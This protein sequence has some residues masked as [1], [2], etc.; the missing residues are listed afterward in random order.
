MRASR[1]VA[2]VVL[3]PLAACTG[4]ESRTPRAAPPTS[5]APASSVTT[6]PS[7]SG[8]LTPATQ[9]V[10]YAAT[11]ARA[12]DTARFTYVQEYENP[13]GRVGRLRGSGVAD[14]LRYRPT[15]KRAEG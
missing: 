11:A 14:L 3:L 7:P 1:T 9:T 10:R 13:D 12:A 6:T 4:G 8:T 15:K 5:A 2:L